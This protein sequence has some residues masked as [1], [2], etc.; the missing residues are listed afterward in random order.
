MSPPADRESWDGQWPTSLQE[1]ETEIP[2][3]KWPPFVS[4]LYQSAPPQLIICIILDG[5]PLMSVLQ[6]ETCIKMTSLLHVTFHHEISI[7]WDVFPI[8][9]FS[10]DSYLVMVFMGRLKGIS[11][12]N[13]Q[14]IKWWKKRDVSVRRCATT[15]RFRKIQTTV[16]KLK[17]FDFIIV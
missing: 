15:R 1:T 6:R 4:V 2:P 17:I 3:S 10:T 5:H 7:S 9:D 8:R 12:A 11:I 13:M 16:G 14:I